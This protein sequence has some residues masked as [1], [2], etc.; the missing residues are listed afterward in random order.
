MPYPG[1]TDTLSLTV[2]PF[3]ASTAATVTVTPP[4]GTV[5][6]PTATTSDGGATW[7]AQ[8]IYPVAGTWVAK[9]T[10]TGTGAGVTEQ[11]IHISVP[12]SPAAAVVWRPER[13]NVAAYV[14]RR[15]LVGAVDGYGNVRYTFAADTHPRGE[16]VDLLVTD[17]CAWVSLLVGAPDETL[18]G[19]AMACAAKYA[20]AQVELSYPDNRDDL[21]HGQQLYEQ[22]VAMRADLD[23]ANAA[24]V[25][26]D[27]EDPASHLLP[28]YSFPAAPSYGDYDW[29]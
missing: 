25:G 2:S 15:T 21:T 13:W 16:A 10:V 19:P 8:P 29:L 3:D 22:A 23:R 7:T 17:A 24:I 9:W 11:I 4:T 1:S 27:P 14:P 20:A 18:H 12:A 5:L 6:T 26:S 28:V